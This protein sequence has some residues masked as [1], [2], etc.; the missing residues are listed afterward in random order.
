MQED[1]QDNT[2][3][4]GHSSVR[5][6]RT[7]VFSFHALLFS[8]QY[9]HVSVVMFSL[10]IVSGGGRSVGTCPEGDTEGWTHSYRSPK[11]TLSFS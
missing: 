5:I 8:L 9:P 6:C 1:W 7:D 2:L 10:V 11:K 3:Y 4:I